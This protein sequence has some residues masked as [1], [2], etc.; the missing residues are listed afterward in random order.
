MDAD[1]EKLTA[2]KKVYADI[3][4][5]TEKEAAARIMVSERKA[6]RLEYELKHAKEDAIQMLTR[7]KH[8]MDSKISEAAAA[9]CTQEKKIAELEAQLQEAEDIV[10]DLREE[11][12][13]VQAELQKFSQI[14]EVKH[15]VQVDNAPAH[16]PI[17]FPPAKVQPNSYINQRNKSQSF[18]NSLLPLKKSLFDNGDLPSIISRSKE[19]ELYKNGCTQRI[20]ACERTTRDNKSPFSVETNDKNKNVNLKLIEKDEVKEI[21]VAADDSCLT[22]PDL[23]KHTKDIPVD[24]NLVRLCKS[25]S[26][27][28]EEIMPVRQEKDK[29]DLPLTS[30]ESKVCV[31]DEA[32]SQSLTDGVIKY[33]RKRKRGV[34][35]SGS[36]SNERSHEIQTAHAGSA[37]GNLIGESTPEKIHLEQVAHQLI[38]LS[39][40]KCW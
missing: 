38:S 34:L 3:I 21:D 12:G 6:V 10:K 40:K 1:D 17:T 25:Q 32:Q 33:T 22:S 9:S 35:I 13:G 36:D 23:V 20:C 19:T 29:V 26:T 28:G 16:E 8:T 11:L 7:L 15:N 24:E 39:D 4:L 5:N 27:S 30:A 14:K 31:T 37:K 18:F 2:L